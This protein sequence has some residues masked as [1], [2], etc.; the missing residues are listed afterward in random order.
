MLTLNVITHTCNMGR[1]QTKTCKVCFK[2]MGGDVL[3]WHMKK[4]EGKA[5]SECNFVTNG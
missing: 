5:G 4:H 2:K 3:Q 1:N